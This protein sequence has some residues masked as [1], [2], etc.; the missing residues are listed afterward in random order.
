MLQILRTM[1]IRTRLAASYVPALLAILLP[2]VLVYSSLR[3]L[4]ELEQMREVF[5]RNRTAAIAAR[6]ETLSEGGREQIQALVADEPGILAIEVVDSPGDP[7]L[8]R[9]WQGEELFRT[10]MVTSGTNQI[11]RAHLPF[12]QKSGEMRLA[13]ID[14]DAR[15]ADFLLVHARH[16]VAFASISGAAL[17][18]LTGYVFWSLRRHAAQE[19]RQ[20]EL[21]H[22][23]HL[24]KLAAILAHEIRTPLATIKGF[25][26]LALEQ[27][28]SQLRPILEPVVSETLR[29]ERLVGDLLLFGRPPQPAFVECGWHDITPLLTDATGKLTVD[30]GPAIR[31]RTDPGLLRQ[32]L[33]NLIRNSCEAMADDPAG[34]VKVSAV[35]TG[36]DLLIAV[37]DNGP[38]IPDA[39]RGK[40]FESFY[41]TKSF[42]TGLGLPIARSLTGALG[43]VFTLTPRNGGGMRAE[44]LL[45]EAVSDQNSG[46]NP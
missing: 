16:N 12:H 37:E 33:S 41:T 8:Q 13:R 3:T 28:G 44:V 22:L 45:R 36:R 24:G 1:T 14:L 39:Q 19:K 20:L 9:L 5:L 40:V 43:G 27:S 30:T 29:L 26:Q 17:L 42:G 25:T 10:E 2:A 31:L 35:A 32:V 18:I 23:A 34:W 15:T 46:V 21:T 6:L 38:G 4:E 11:F 7:E